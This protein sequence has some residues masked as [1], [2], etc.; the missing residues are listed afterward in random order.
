MYCVQGP[1]V[2]YSDLDVQGFIKLVVFHAL[3]APEILQRSGHG[4]AVDWWSLGTLMFDMLTGA[5]S[6][7]C[8]T[9]CVY[10]PSPVCVIAFVHPPCMCACMYLCMYMHVCVILKYLRSYG[11]KIKSKREKG[12]QLINWNCSLSRMT[13]ICCYVFLSDSYHAPMQ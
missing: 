7:L 6:L 9:P 4:K 13:C 8:C 3:R 2:V 5:V 1:T 12:E 10:Q 11:G